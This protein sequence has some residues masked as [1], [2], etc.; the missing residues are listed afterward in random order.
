MLET[1]KYH[2]VSNRNSSNLP[3][4]SSH[5]QKFVRL[6]TYIWYQVSTFNCPRDQLIHRT[7]FER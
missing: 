4:P 6:P 3:K 2:H 7:S 1:T 5:L